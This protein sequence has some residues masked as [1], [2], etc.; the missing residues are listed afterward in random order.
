MDAADLDIEEKVRST[1]S[2][3]EP[4]AGSNPPPW[5]AITTAAHRQRRQASRRRGAIATALVV[6]V[7]LG[8][9]FSVARQRSTRDPSVTA[10]AS[11]SVPPATTSPDATAGPTGSIAAF[12]A[13]AAANNA[14]HQPQPTPQAAAR[15]SDVVLRGRLGTVAPGREIW[16]SPTADTPAFT[17]FTIE[18]AVTEMLG[19]SKPQ[20]VSG[21]FLVEVLLSGR[22]TVEQVRRAAPATDVVLFLSD[23]TT[24][25]APTEARG[26]KAGTTYLAPLYQG[27]LMGGAAGEIVSLNDTYDEFGSGWTRYPNLDELASGLRT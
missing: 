25:T 4:A 1:L 27:F 18:V 16:G 15:D 11:T 7:V 23:Y 24:P 8:V 5:S 22:V 10:S 20:L 2:T 12:V 6:V 14:D 17:T 3:V 21:P 13:V 26:S 9:S 19:G